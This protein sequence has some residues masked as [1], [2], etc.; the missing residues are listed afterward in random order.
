[1]LHT[2]AS[3]FN[4]TE[5]LKK[6]GFWSEVNKALPASVTFSSTRHDPRR[7]RLTRHGSWRGPRQHELA[8]S[9]HV[10]SLPRRHAWRGTVYLP[11][12]AWWRGQ[13]AYFWKYFRKRVKIEICFKFGLKIKKNR[14]GGSRAIPH[15]REYPTI[16]V[17]FY[18]NICI[19]LYI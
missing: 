12:H 14:H 7:G 2:C 10:A 17:H 13:T 19:S 15:S 6:I 4:V 5:N 11:R 9:S 8:G 3:K 1:M 16:L 18:V